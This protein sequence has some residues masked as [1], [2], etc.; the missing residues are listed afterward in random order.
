MSSLS[1]SS[2]S[3]KKNDTV[4]VG[5]KGTAPLVFWDGSG[6]EGPYSGIANYGANLF[7][8]FRKF[9]VAPT[10]VASSLPFFGHDQTVIAKPKIFAPLGTSKLFWPEASFAKAVELAKGRRSVF[11]GLANIN[12]PIW[13]KAKNF[14]TVI[15]VQDLIPFFAPTQV[16]TPFFLQFS[17]AMKRLVQKVDAI[18][19]CSEW[20][21]RTVR[22]KFPNLRAKVVVVRIGRPDNFVPGSKLDESGKKS[23]LTV[24]RF[25]PYKNLNI[26]GSI[27]KKADSALT[28][29]LVSDE[30]CETFFRE[31]FAEL[32]M[33]GRIKIY[34]KLSEDALNTLFMRANCYF[35]PSSFE[36]FCIPAMT[37]ASCGLPIAYLNGSATGE[38]ALPDFSVGVDRVDTDAFLEAIYLAMRKTENPD[39]LENTKKL[40]LKF[41]TWDDAAL[42]LKN[43]YTDLAP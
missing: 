32:V 27:A 11:H 8:A 29:H 7:T 40:F 31:N 30:R 43:L 33:S 34:K 36:G 41:P 35:Q 2:G 25:E 13:S 42:K 21:A 24:S 23:V 19:C 16:S 39:F 10:I 12:A 15:S 22:E 28:F 38:T 1:G 3:K 9:D 20:T 17:F 18:V 37:A 6:L 14:A 5:P 4:G 26:I